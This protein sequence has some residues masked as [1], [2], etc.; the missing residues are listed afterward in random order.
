M[1]NFMI[2]MFDKVDY[3]KYS[4][5][6]REEFYGIQAA[7]FEDE[8]E[9]RKL[10]ELIDEKKIGIHFPIVP[11]PLKCRDPLFLSPDAGDR[12]ASYR[13]FENELA[14]AA[15][16]DADYLLAHFPKPALL[17]RNADW[18]NWRF[19]N[20][21]EWM[22]E[23]EYPFE[24]FARSCEEM[25]G[26]LSE[27]QEKHRVKIIL[28]H[29]AI[30]K[31]LYEGTLLVDLLEKY[32]NIKLCLDT[33]RLHLQDKIDPSFDSFKFVEQYA[34][35]TYL[36]HL[37]DVKVSNSLEGGHHPV[38]PGHKVEEGWADTA[39]YMDIISAAN[40][41][42]K[43]MFEHRS[44]LISDDQLQSCYEWIGSFFT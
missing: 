12:E 8:A 9:L 27:L 24:T 19:A 16:Y 38:L 18:S 30:N 23:E 41:D 20:A 7:T 2:G 22:W 21:H 4:R 11:E 17:D 29:D 33:G 43:I 13:A 31:Y 40:K 32:N 1:K 44:D 35:Y 37:W 6:F 42:V 26:R 28:E 10:R 36:V 14:I 34:R 5:D 39:R 25:F 15:R 3:G